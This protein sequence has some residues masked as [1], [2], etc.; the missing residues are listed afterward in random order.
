MRGRSF[1]P[2]GDNDV[3]PPA[4]T[5]VITDSGR[6][7]DQRRAGNRGY[8]TDQLFGATVEQAAVIKSPAALPRSADATGRRSSVVG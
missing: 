8:V 1:V 5:Q 4:T 6:G 7:I 2:R 3:R